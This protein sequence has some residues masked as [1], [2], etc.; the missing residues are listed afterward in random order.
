[1]R[2]LSV[3]PL[4][5]SSIT[6][7]LRNYDPG[8]VFLESALIVSDELLDGDLFYFTSPK[9]LK[10]S[11]P[12]IE[13][14]FAEEEQHYLII[15]RTAKLAK[16]VFLWAEGF[17]GQFSDNYFDLIPGFVYEVRFPKELSLEEFK[18]SMKVI[19]LRQTMD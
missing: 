11:D 17:S 12:G 8:S 19:H 4:F 9:N 7:L 14:D 5:S 6:E 2:P 13:F 18:E 16:N 10:L 3:T 15:I 1:M